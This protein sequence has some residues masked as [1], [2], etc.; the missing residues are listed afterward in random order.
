MISSLTDLRS[1]ARFQAT[2]NSSNTDFSDADTLLFANQYYGQ[3]L[4]LVMGNEKAN[5]YRDTEID[6]KNI[7]AGSNLITPDSDMQS[8]LRVAIKYPASATDY[9]P[10][11]FISIDSIDCDIDSYVPESFEYTLLDGSIVI[12]VGVEK[13]LIE[14]VTSG[15]KIYN[16]NE[17]TELSGGTDTPKLIEQF[18]DYIST[19]MAWEYCNANELYTKADRIKNRMKELEQGLKQHNAI[20]TKGSSIQVRSENYE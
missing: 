11:K 4:S 16:Y 12:F 7:T 19:G 20:F 1:A 13:S 9:T 18:R 6:S 10:A 2:G 17:I 3:A 14:A 15:V 8:I 5:L